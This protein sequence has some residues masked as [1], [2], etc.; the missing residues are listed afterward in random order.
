MATMVVAIVLVMILIT[1]V[2]AR[3]K[4]TEPVKGPPLHSSKVLPDLLK[5]SL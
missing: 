5:K 3:R 1:V 2:V 4:K